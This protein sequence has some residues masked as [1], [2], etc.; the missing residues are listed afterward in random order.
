MDAVDIYE[1]FRR[2]QGLMPTARLLDDAN[3]AVRREIRPPINNPDEWMYEPSP[4][5]ESV[6]SASAQVLKKW[7]L[8]FLELCSADL[9]KAI[10]EV[11]P[12][13]HDPDDG[14]DAYGWGKTWWQVLKIHN[15]AK[16]LF[17]AVSLDNEEDNYQRTWR[18]GDFKFADKIKDALNVIERYEPFADVLLQMEVL[19][20]MPGYRDPNEPPS[21]SPQT[22][23]VATDEAPEE[24]SKS[25]AIRAENVVARPPGSALLSSY[26]EVLLRSFDD[27]G[28][29][30]VYEHV[31]RG[32]Q[33]LLRADTH[34]EG[35]QLATSTNDQSP[36]I[37][38]DA[39]NGST[40]P[41]SGNLSTNQ[42]GYR[43]GYR[44]CVKRFMASDSDDID[45]Q[46]VW[47]ADWNKN[48]PN[49][50]PLQYATFR[51]RL[52]EARKLKSAHLNSSK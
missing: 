10:A 14:R 32:V 36:T 17:V 23:L 2:I 50:K 52:S 4:L 33:P 5:F 40:A 39:K 43:G 20:A 25:L 41:T 11:E 13:N 6:N 47:V 30:A 16:G 12:E 21:L 35:R 42:S 8:Y 9:L 37:P 34:N 28:K 1:R 44:E 29:S 27:S 48:H 24:L 49:D 51:A 46:K 18:N 45:I 38:R 19:K 26:E 3:S 15:A 22:P 31:E 7:C